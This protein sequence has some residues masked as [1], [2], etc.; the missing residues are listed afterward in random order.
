[1]T[2]TNFFTA[3]IFGSFCFKTK[4]TEMFLW[5]IELFYF[6]IML[7]CEAEILLIPILNSIEPKKPKGP[8]WIWNRIASHLIRVIVQHR[9]QGQC[10]INTPR[11]SPR[12]G[13]SCYSKIRPRGFFDLSFLSRGFAPLHPGLQDDPPRCGS[14]ALAFLRGAPGCMMLPFQGCSPTATAKNHSK[15]PFSTF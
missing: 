6:S 14:A 12:R 8:Q 2:A 10:F 7:T 11:E 4:W 5:Q 15:T 3:W 13:S 9:V 1:V